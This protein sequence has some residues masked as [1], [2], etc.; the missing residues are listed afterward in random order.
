MQMNDSHHHQHDSHGARHSCMGMNFKKALIA[1]IVINL[2]YVGAEFISGMVFDSVGLISD[3]GHNLSDVVSLILS[4]ASVIV[5][6]RSVTS[7]FTY[8]YGKST[9]LVSLVNSILLLF[10]VVFI[11]YES[12]DKFANPRP[13][14]GSIIAWVAALGILVNALTAFL[15]FS[16][17]DKDINIKGAWLHMIADALVSLGVVIS[18]MVISWTGWSMIDPIM[19]LIIAGVILASTWGLLCESFRLT[20]DGVPSGFDTNKILIKMKSV[21]GVKDVH[22]LHLWALSTTEVALTAHLVLPCDSSAEEIDKIKNCV[23][24]Y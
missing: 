9:I 13:V 23:N 5:A 16:G 4:L 11:V 20:L 22:H 2:I 24:R 21:S 15:F 7:G 1:G 12:I 14:A 6:S 10:T 3:A 8:G 17:K 18:G 19:G